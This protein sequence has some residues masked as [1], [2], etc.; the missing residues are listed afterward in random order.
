ML[1]D[2]FKD[3]MFDL[4]ACYCFEVMPFNILVLFNN[5]SVYTRAFHRYFS[6]FSSSTKLDLNISDMHYVL[7]GKRRSYAMWLHDIEVL[8]A[9]SDNIEEISMLADLHNLAP[10]V[11]KV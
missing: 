7:V 11:N 3:G 1:S 10:L 9:L 5:Y 2:N 6:A 4:Q 8:I